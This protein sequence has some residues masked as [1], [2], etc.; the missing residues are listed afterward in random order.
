MTSLKHLHKN[1]P[2]AKLLQAF[3]LLA[4]LISGEGVASA[5]CMFLAERNDL[6]EV[7]VHH[8][9][10]GSA[11]YVLSHG[12]GTTEP[13]R[14]FS[15]EQ[16]ISKRQTEAVLISVA[17]I[18]AVTTAAVISANNANPGSIENTN[19]F[20]DNVFW[21]LSI[22]PNIIINNPFQAPFMPA[23]GLLRRYTLFPGDALQG[24]VKVKAR[25][26]SYQHVLVEV[27]VD[28]AYLK[29]HFGAP[30]RLR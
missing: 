2:L 25:N 7:M 26:S 29:Y 15:A 13:F 20:D 1:R 16:F 22:S 10:D 6:H 17:A 21:W 30:Q 28:S 23:D 24:G 11:I 3:W 12:D 9:E 19:D 8:L 18:A 14:V 5:I 4:W 27:P